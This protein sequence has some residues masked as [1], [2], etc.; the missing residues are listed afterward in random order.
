[1]SKAMAPT[2]PPGDRAGLTAS[3]DSPEAS[4]RAAP[5]RQNTLVWGASV[6]AHAALLVLLT[7][8]VFSVA[9]E[10]ET[11]VVVTLPPAEATAWTDVPR[12]GE[13]AGGAP[14]LDR[15]S[16]QALSEATAAPVP[17]PPVPAALGAASLSAEA[18]ASLD[19]SATDPALAILAE[20]ADAPAATARVGRGANP[21][22][23]GVGPGARDAIA[24]IGRQG[25]DVVFVLD[26]TDSMAETIEQA[27]A[28]ILDI[29]GV[30]TGMLGD[31]AQAGG[32][33]KGARFGV[34]AFKDFGDDYGL[35]PT[36]ILP[37]NADAQKLETFMNQIFVGGGGDFPEPLHVALEDATDAKKMGWSRGRHNI[38]VLVS[39]AQVHSNGRKASL[40]VAKRFVRRLGGTVN[41]IDVDPDRTGVLADLGNI[42]VAGEGSA[43]RIEDQSAFWKQLIVSVFPRRFEHDVALIVE[44]YASH[45]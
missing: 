16:E 5:W 15:V 20:L 38:V 13:D 27:K 28:R 32:V 10:P 40:N 2:P 11:E 26:A 34:V 29:H 21:L 9:E 7:L 14:S 12:D 39:D 45:E 1:M 36:R 44:R 6:A 41:V 8:V 35:H 22:L 17:A 19:P 3:A 25:L 18:L 30:V 42:A 33:R 4:G 23:D 31:A 37:L 43:F 24:R